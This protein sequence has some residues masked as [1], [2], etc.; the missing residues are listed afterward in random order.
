MSEEKT[1]FDQWCLVELMGHVRIAGK[2]T[3]EPLF[4]TS[5]LRVD[6]PGENGNTTMTRYFGGGAIYSITPLTKEVAMALAARIK[7]EPV[8]PYDIP[9][10]RQL[11][12]NAGERDED[13]GYGGTDDGED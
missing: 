4:G 5:L 3:E 11:S 12:L 7:P 13:H 1:V 10:L 2:V 6:V 8:T 9:Q